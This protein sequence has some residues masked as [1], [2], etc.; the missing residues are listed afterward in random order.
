MVSDMGSKTLEEAL[1]S[2]DAASA[3]TLLNA[4]ADPNA[5]TENSHLPLFLAAWTGNGGLVQL[6]MDSGASP[7]RRDRIFQATALHH[8]TSS[9]AALPLLKAG[10]DVNAT[11]NEGRTPLHQ[12]ASIG[13][14]SLVK[15][16]LKEGANPNQGSPPPL[17]AA[18][19]AGKTKVAEVLLAAG[20]DPN[21]AALEGITPLM[22]AARVRNK[23]AAD[24]IQVLLSGG[25][26]P[27]AQQGEGDGRSPLWWAAVEGTVEAVKAI[28]AGGAAVDLKT[29]RYG[30]TALT[31][32]AYEGRADTAAA[33]LAA[34]AD[35]D[36]CIADNHP[37]PERRGKSARELAAI[38]RN[39]KIQSLFSK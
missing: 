6:L 9:A 2:Q 10:L 11:S 19:E 35:P 17:H 38:S 15:L 30:E 32:A 14:L 12:A 18:V 28:L 34:G 29:S 27:N 26:N 16:F 37:D 20:A 7:A 39:N 24:M 13:D 36:A 22:K 4:G 25:A 1:V 33:L 31:A 21:T 3:R 23:R 5:E 8:A